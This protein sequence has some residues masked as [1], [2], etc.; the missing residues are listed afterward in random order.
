MLCCRDSVGHG[1]PSGDVQ[2]LWYGE[3]YAGL[4]DL[5]LFQPQQQL[6]IRCKPDPA[7]SLI[8]LRNKVV[9]GLCAESSPA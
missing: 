7:V 1:C 6:P 8:G 2:G 3:P 5:E 4:L 9:H